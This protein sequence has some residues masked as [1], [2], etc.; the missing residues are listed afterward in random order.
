MG[1][2]GPSSDGP[3][4]P[5][6]PPPPREPPTDAVAVTPDQSVLKAV[7]IEGEGDP[8]ALH[9]RC[10]GERKR[11]VCGWGGGEGGRFVVGVDV[12]SPLHQPTLPSV[13]YTGYLAADNTI[14]MRSADEARHGEPA[15][16]VAGRASSLTATG[17]NAGVATMRPGETA[18]LWVAP[19]AGYG[20]KGS[21]SFP[22]VPP[23]AHLTYTV[24]LVAA[25]P[26]ED[27]LPLRDMTYEDRLDASARRRADGNAALKEGDANKALRFYAL[28]LS[29]V[30]DDDFLFQLHGP[31]LD[32]A[33]AAVTSARLN[34]A[35]AKLVAGDARGAATDAT[36]VL[37]EAPRNAKALYRRGVARR[38]LGDVEGAVADLTAAAAVA[39][40]DS[41]V[42]KE[43]AAA[44]ADARATRAAGDAVVAAA[45]KQEVQQQE[46]TAEQP[47]P[48]V[49]APGQASAVEGPLATAFRVM[50][51]FAVVAAVVVAVVAYTVARW[52][53]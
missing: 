25:D 23:G 44:R 33:N 3:D 22:S 39:P 6:A 30:D 21:F 35:A 26:P 53:A 18:K 17:L 37:K 29:F 13:H 10:L 20:G 2:P 9:S 45:L 46:S 36:R 1:D 19:S 5:P 52:M 43:L 48:P 51:F 27:A 28:A 16:V 24:T 4:P 14:F 12:F 40:R 50:T 31:H 8:P 11:G 42:R 41:G 38:R 34:A 47:Q 7:V 32:A 15:V 49:R